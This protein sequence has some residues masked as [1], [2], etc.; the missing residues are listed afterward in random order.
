LT[1]NELTGH[2]SRAASGRGR[3]A[4]DRI[5]RA[6]ALV[7]DPAEERA[8]Q[9]G[10]DVLQVHPGE[11]ILEIGVGT[12]RALIGLARAAGPRGRI[13]GLDLSSG[14]LRIARRRMLTA[15]TPIHVFQGDARE[16]ALRNST[17][18]GAFMSFT[19]ELF[20]DAG[21]GIALSEVRRVLRRGGR[22]AIVCL[23]AGSTRSL[24]M[25]AY[26]WLHR[27]LPHLLDCRPIK[28][29]SLLERSGFTLCRRETMRLWGLRV[30]VVLAVPR[31]G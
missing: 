1:S 30:A 18:D 20:D 26:A 10:L 29:Q 7:A 13:C 15:A 17:F 11:R 19:L 16:L 4:Y 9:R 24:A 23:S 22:L 14:M 28:I 12:G 8:R 27:Q 21:I 6:Y 5:S 31:Q 3:A 25:S 2:A